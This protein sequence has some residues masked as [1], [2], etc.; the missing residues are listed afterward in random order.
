MRSALFITSLNPTPHLTAGQ[1]AT[2][3]KSSLKR[4]DLWL[5]SFLGG[6]YIYLDWM[7]SG[8]GPKEKS[9]GTEHLNYNSQ[10]TLWYL[11]QSLLPKFP[12]CVST[13]FPTSCPGQQWKVESLP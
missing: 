8:E 3:K 10:E 9:E 13:P 1:P 11:V 6:S 5:I 7:L 4:K 2:G 12:V